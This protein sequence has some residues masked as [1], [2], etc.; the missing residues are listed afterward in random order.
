MLFFYD[1]VFDLSKAEKDLKNFKVLLDSK[2]EVGESEL[3]QFFDGNIQLLWLLGYVTG[4]D[5]PVK[6]CAE[7]SVFGKYRTDYIVTNADQ[8]KLTFVEFEEAKL[9]SIFKSKPA[10][11]STRYDWSNTFEHGVSQV[12][13][14][15][16]LLSENYGTDLMENEFG[17]RKIKYQ[18]VVVA[19]RDKGIPTKEQQNRLDWRIE[20]T[21]INSKHIQFFT[22][23]SLYKEMKEQL[24]MLKAI[25]A[26]QP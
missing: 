4:I 6:Y 2:T 22:F 15:F 7:S 11:T 10:Q 12:T 25:A 8:T 9:N 13:D 5:V 3:Q 16:Y 21:V 20:N 1:C 24:N 19:G 14:W 18:G 26:P 17:C 23:D